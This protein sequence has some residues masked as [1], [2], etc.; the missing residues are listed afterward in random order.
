MI[1]LLIIRH[2]GVQDAAHSDT[3]WY[4][5]LKTGEEFG[6]LVDTLPIVTERVNS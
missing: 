5:A 4:L 1:E 6:L 3:A 2:S